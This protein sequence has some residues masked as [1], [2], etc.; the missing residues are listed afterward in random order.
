LDETGIEF[1]RLSQPHQLIVGW[2]SPTQLSFQV[3]AQ[4]T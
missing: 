1:L 2:G 3:N 4:V